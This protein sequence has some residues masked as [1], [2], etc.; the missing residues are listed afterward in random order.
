[1]GVDS[2]R[3]SRDGE[4]ASAA[5]QV[6]VALNNVLSFAGYMDY[7]LIFMAYLHIFLR[8]V[9]CNFLPRLI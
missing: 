6:G 8:P 2:R 1:M 4:H 5:M 7:R 9:V 3:D